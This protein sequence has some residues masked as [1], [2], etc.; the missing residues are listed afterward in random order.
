MSVVALVDL[1]VVENLIDRLADVDLVHDVVKIVLAEK[2]LR[3]FL[4]PAGVPQIA[5]DVFD[6]VVGMFFHHVLDILVQGN[7]RLLALFFTD[8]LPVFEVVETAKTHR[9]L[10]V[11]AVFLAAQFYGMLSHS[12]H[13]DTVHDRLISGINLCMGCD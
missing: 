12:W 13:G 1:H 10:L 8:L 2:L 3:L 5:L 11:L 4:K 6:E 7:G 9:R